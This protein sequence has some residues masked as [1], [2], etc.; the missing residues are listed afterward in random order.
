MYGLVYGS[1]LQ[2]ITYNK[3]SIDTASDSIVINIDIVCYR[4]N[5]NVTEYLMNVLV[6]KIPM[7]K[8]ENENKIEKD[9]GK[10]SRIKISLIS[11]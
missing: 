11:L 10:P 7:K 1:V 4:E 8:D 5:N 9:K 6:F 2:G 3:V